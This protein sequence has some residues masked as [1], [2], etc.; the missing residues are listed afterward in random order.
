MKG[1]TDYGGGSLIAPIFEDGT[2]LGI[3]TPPKAL[4]ALAQK[5]VADATVT[6]T[7]DQIRYRAIDIYIQTVTAYQQQKYYSSRWAR[8]NG[9]RTSPRSSCPFTLSPGPTSTSP[10]RN[11]PNPGPSTSRARGSSRAG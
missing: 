11:W 8:W 2:F 5:R 1:Y 10:T 6:L 9:R 3:N 4:I 7:R